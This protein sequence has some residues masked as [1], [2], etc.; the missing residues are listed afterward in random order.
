MKLQYKIE[1]I[2]Q[3]ILA[4]DTWEERYQYLIDLGKTAPEFPNYLKTQERIIRSCQA[5]TWLDFYD[6][7]GR[8]YISGT[9]NSIFVQGFIHLLIKL[10]SKE[11]I[12]DIHSD[13]TPFLS[14]I[15]FQEMVTPQ[16][17]T[18]L[19]AIYKK[20]KNYIG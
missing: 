2:I 1:I 9:S 8:L 6:E 11:L 14:L 17:G 15:G 4:L 12:Q 13:T 18:G 3:P 16:R 19:L 20:I 10:Y 5:I 7:A